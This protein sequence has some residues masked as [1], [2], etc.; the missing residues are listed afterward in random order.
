ML[1]KGILPALDATQ[2]PV[3][4]HFG[5]AEREALLVDF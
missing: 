3:L 2:K 4:P 5:E 1:P